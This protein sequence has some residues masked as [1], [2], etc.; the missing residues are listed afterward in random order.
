[1]N[2]HKKGQT[3]PDGN[4]WNLKVRNILTLL[5]DFSQLLRALMT[6]HE[7]LRCFLDAFTLSPWPNVEKILVHARVGSHMW[8]VWG[9]HKMAYHRNLKWNLEIWMR[10]K[11]NTYLWIRIIFCIIFAIIMKN[12]ICITTKT[13]TYNNY[14]A[15]LSHIFEIS[16]SFKRWQICEFFN[17]TWYLFI[18]IADLSYNLHSSQ[19]SNSNELVFLNIQIKTK[20][21][22]RRLR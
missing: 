5:T 1:M 2:E 22:Q 15:N 4:L 9:E 18:K 7:N 8:D 17:F 16:R 21:D 3:R 20:A 11:Y 12:K 13:I 10:C 19:Q 6:L 14:I